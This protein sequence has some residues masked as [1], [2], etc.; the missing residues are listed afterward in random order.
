MGIIR[1]LLTLG[2]LVVAAV[3][4]WP[5]SVGL[6]TAPI[7]GQVV[8]LRAGIALAALGLIVILLIVR[9]FPGFRKLSG[10]LAL[11]LVLCII[12]NVGILA[13]RGFSGKT[14]TASATSITVLEWNTEGENVPADTIAKLALAEHADIVTLPETTQAL[15]EAVALA[16]K[17][18][19]QPM[20]SNTVTFDGEYKAQSTTI[21]LSPSLGNYT[22]TS[23]SGSGP[24]LNTNTV[25]TVVAKPESG[26]GPT[27]VAV[28]AVSPRAGQMA[29]WR[30]DLSWVASQCQGDD[31]ILAGDF[32]STVDNMAGLGTGGGTLGNCADAGIAASGAAIGTWPTSLPSYLGAPIDHVMATAKYR[33]TGFS[34]PSQYDSAGS[35]HRPLITELEL[36]D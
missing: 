19:G 17:A 15:G 4:T 28:H 21:L 29:N 13:W 27:I 14:P 22:V 2:M 23:Y 16:M 11:V 24:P 12:A 25:P 26:T 10:A 1:L 5:Q 33:V 32:N 6:Q 20:W 8:A 18:G 30:S 7:F 34:V 31:V 9:L 3:I 36:K 35:D